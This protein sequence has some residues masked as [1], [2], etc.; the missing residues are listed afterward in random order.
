MNQY[1][2]VKVSMSDP[3]CTYGLIFC[4]IM[5]AIITFH[6]SVNYLCDFGVVFSY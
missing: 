1:L 2:P 3:Y 5:Y 6:C 4:S